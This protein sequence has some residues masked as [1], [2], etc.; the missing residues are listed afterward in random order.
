MVRMYI[1][2]TSTCCTICIPGAHPLYTYYTNIKIIGKTFVL[3]TSVVV[4]TAA[5]LDAHNIQM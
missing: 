5:Q 1:V 2:C 4:K 3:A